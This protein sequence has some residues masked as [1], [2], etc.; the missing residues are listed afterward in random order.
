MYKSVYT[1]SKKNVQESDESTCLQDQIVELYKEAKGTMVK[2]EAYEVDRLEV[3]GGGG[4]MHLLSIIVQYVAL[5]L[6]LL[7]RHIITCSIVC[8]IQYKN[9]F[10][11][12]IVV[13]LQWR[14]IS[15]YTLLIVCRFLTSENNTCS[16][17]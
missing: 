4:T 14:V 10:D 12:Y 13:L 2:C 1:K 6:F 9:E 5:H 16:L 17:N 15:F 8:F 3:E 7:F 11:V